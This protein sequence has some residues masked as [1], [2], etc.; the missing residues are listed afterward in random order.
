MRKIIL[1]LLVLAACKRHSGGEGAIT[2]AGSTSVQPFAEKWGEAYHEEHGVEIT[3][4]GGGST[5]GVKATTDG[6]ADIG[7][8]SRELKP[9]EAG[10]VTATIVAHDAE[11][12]I[13]HPSNPV[14]DLT[15]D[16]LR[17][18]YAGDI[19]N[20]K[21]VG[22]PDKK[23]NVVTREAGS[24]SRG[25]FEELAMKGKTIASSALVQNSQGA[26][27]QLVAGDPG[28]IGY[29]SHGVVDKSV[30]ALKL[31]GVEVSFET[32]KAGT[33]VLY[34]PFLFLTKGPPTGQLKEFIDWVLGPEGQAI[35]AK[36]G[37]F[38]PK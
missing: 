4:Q 22:G 35:A 29:V 34:R 15:V 8:C 33:Y 6:A 32:V 25:A 18:I 23:I 7:T 9:D 13:V 36:E 14:S 24:G 16:Q 21:D 20:W 19:T 30:K 12:V 2:I 11:A 31:G 27:R 37:L 3:V 28:A 17:G 5:A 1:L 10:K 26:V 38:P